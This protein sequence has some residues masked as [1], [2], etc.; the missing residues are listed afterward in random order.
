[1]DDEELRLLWEDVEGRIDD[2]CHDLR[3]AIEKIENVPKAHQYAA[4]K[5]AEELQAALVNAEINRD[6]DDDNSN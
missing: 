3:T 6:V 5:L 1:M 4:M 2:I